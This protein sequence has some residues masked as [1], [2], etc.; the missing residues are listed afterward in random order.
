MFSIIFTTLMHFR[1][2]GND[3]QEE[4]E[5]DFQKDSS[6]EFGEGP[7]VEASNNSLVEQ[8]K[9]HFALSL[10]AKFLFMSQI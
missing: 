9:H 2:I 5:G 8:G 4:I 3:I 1:N 10:V 7:E 6:T